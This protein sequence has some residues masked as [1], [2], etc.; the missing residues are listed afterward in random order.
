MQYPA[1]VTLPEGNSQLTDTI[2]EM[3]DVGS[4]W[5]MWGVPRR[6]LQ[7]ASVTQRHSSISGF[8]AACSGCENA[9]QRWVVRSRG[10]ILTALCSYVRN[11]TVGSK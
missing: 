6:L 4:Q 11:M 2:L 7:H 5:D 10:N 9:R 1:H 8:M 3:T